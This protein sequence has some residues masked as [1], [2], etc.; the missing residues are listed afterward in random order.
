ML[1]ESGL[2]LTPGMQDEKNVSGSPARE[3][4]VPPIPSTPVSF[5]GHRARRARATN[6]ARSHARGS[7]R[8]EEQYPRDTYKNETTGPTSK[9]ARARRGPPQVRNLSD[10]SRHE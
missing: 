10:R 9:A 1:F 8:H 5:R 6:E 2:K 4:S 3:G 7:E